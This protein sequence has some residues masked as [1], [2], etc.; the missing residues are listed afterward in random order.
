MPVRR[1]RWSGDDGEVFRDA[2][3]ID[4]ATRACLDYARERLSLDPVP[5]DRAMT[6]QQ[7]QER[8]GQTITPAGA[9]PEVVMQLF[10][11]VLSAGCISTDHQRYFAFIPAAPTKLSLVFDLVVGASGINASSWLEASG[12]V[13]AENQ[14]L[15]WLADLAGLPPS[16]GGCFVSGGSA[17]NLSALVAARERA[18]RR[19]PVPPGQVRVAVSDQAHSSIGSALRMMDAFTLVVPTG[20]DGRLTGAALQAALE[21]D[22]DPTTVVAVV[23]TAGTTNAG[24]V[25]DLAGIASVAHDRGLWFH[26]DGAYGAAALAAPSARARFAGIELAD[27]LVV[28]PHKWLFAPVD[29]CALLYRDPAHARSVHTQHASYLDAI[30]DQQADPTAEWNPSDHAYHLTRRARGLPFWFSLA[31]YGTDAYAAAVEQVL[32]TTRA[33]AALVDDADHLELVHEPELSILLFRRHGW[34][35]EDYDRW[36]RSLLDDQVAFVLPSLWHDETVA[37]LALLNPETTLDDVAV[38]LESTAG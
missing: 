16:A 10:D 36:C 27:S 18:R 38:V 28:D 2:E 30:H 24:I 8:A 3:V 23:A 6:P 14:A 20:D 15:R 31:V 35:P 21:Q 34:Q 32:E 5:L 19:H 9:D 4:R 29:C 13:Y 25:D 11:D 26:V 37:R 12:A 33:A 7:L 22:P 1:A 17:G